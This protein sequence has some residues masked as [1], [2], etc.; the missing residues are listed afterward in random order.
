[1]AGKRR[2]GDFVLEREIGRG[3]MGV[4]Y[5]A[6][7]QSIARTVALKLLPPFAGM[8]Q[9]AVARFRREAEAAGRL[10]H[11]GIVP[12]HAVGEA[13][14]VY[15]YAMELIEGPNLG[16]LVDRLGMRQPDK[17]RASLIEEV[18]LAARYPASREPDAAGPA[19]RYVRSC[20]RLCIEIANALA[21]AHKERVIH[22]DLKPSN[23]LIHPSGRPVL[24]DFG[25]ARDERLE[26]LTLSGDQIGTPSYMAPEQASGRGILDARVDVYGLGAVLYE[27]LTLRPPFDGGTAAEIMLRIQIEAPPPVRARNPQVPLDLAAIVHKCLAKLPDARYPAIESLELDLRSFLLGRRVSARLPG[28][29]LRLR[30][31]LQ[32]QRR[33]L[34]T[35]VV[36]AA[37]ATAIAVGVGVVDHRADRLEGSERLADAGRELQAGHPDRARDLYLEAMVLTGDPARVR[38]QRQQDFRAAFASLYAADRS[39]LERFQAEF[40]ADD[41]QALRPELDQLAGR[42]KLVFG[43]L[44]AA[45]ATRTT[46]VRV[47]SVKDGALEDAWREVAVGSPLPTGEYLVRCTAADGATAVQWARVA[48]D[49][50]TELWPQYF[51]AAELPP[52]FV[53]AHEPRGHRFFLA[54]ECELTRGEWRAFVEQT[55]DA[56]LCAELLPLAVGDGEP[57]DLPVRGLSLRQAQA[58]AARHAGHL[59]SLRE[60]WLL[61]SGGLEG[62]RFPWGGHADAARV[63]GDPF[64]LTAPEAVCSRPA[65]RSPFG[66]FHV[67]GNVA[68]LLAPLGAAEAAAGGGHYLDDPKTLAFGDHALP[69]LQLADAGAQQPFVGMRLCRFLPLVESPRAAEHA[70]QRRDELRRGL[71]GYA[72]H[73]W[74]VDRDGSVHCLLELNGV[75]D[76]RDRARSLAFATPGFLQTAT[77][78]WVRPDQL[79]PASCEPGL[80]RETTQL[81]FRLPDSVHANQGYRLFIASDLLPTS[82]LRP[83]RDTFALRLPMKRGQKTP[84]VYTLTLPPGGDVIDAQPTP[85]TWQLNG[86]TVLSWEST[87]GEQIETATVRL[88]QDGM[89]GGRLRARRSVGQQLD[90]FLT[91]WNARSPALAAAMAP[92]FVLRPAG[93]DRQSVLASAAGER[94][95]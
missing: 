69:L 88:R 86:C 74:V 83:E 10:A 53:V 59:P 33:T 62:L 22:R 32:R 72:F 39:V 29:W 93:R 84:M 60:L 80:G 18:Q 27:L 3:G 66:A 52:G 19:N 7:Q 77:R 87:A 46:A 91:A 54:G 5:L 94:F 78:L 56:E 76:G 45:H 8:D 42:G 13:D 16:D 38:R 65:G 64:H 95:E 41:R 55:T 61:G 50:Q 37:V 58:Y 43:Q 25:L 34:V 17:L 63:V 48:A 26:R 35:S 90:D 81:G 79:L 1:A 4:V 73:D 89:L 92:D 2:L 9:A 85:V 23:I 68:E 28:T 21:A 51:T 47:L 6:T 82:G 12:I 70:E 11:P 75:Y 44:G 20:V 24:V 31:G 49:Q 30:A 57:D 36:A 15:F 14:G 67:L 71:L 40:D